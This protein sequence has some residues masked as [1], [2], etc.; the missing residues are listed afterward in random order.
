MNVIFHCSNMFHLLMYVLVPQLILHHLFEIFWISHLTCK[1]R[2][3]PVKYSRKMQYSF[4][5]KWQAQTTVFL[6]QIAS[7]SSS[8]C[9]SNK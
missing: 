1:H 9:Q 7:D 4:K 5:K 3:L 2:L 6:L 8:I